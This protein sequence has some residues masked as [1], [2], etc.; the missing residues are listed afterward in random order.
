MASTNAV[1]DEGPG[2]AN[3]ERRTVNRKRQLTQMVNRI[4][5]RLAGLVPE[6]GVLGSD[7][8]HGRHPP[9]I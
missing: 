9:L 7:L 8:Y 5:Y 1:E 3:G 4:L 2:A 6:A